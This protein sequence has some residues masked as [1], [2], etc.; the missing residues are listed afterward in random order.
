M[1]P[2]FQQLAPVDVEIRNTNIL[3]GPFH[4]EMPDIHP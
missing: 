2:T 4:A 3:G 1:Y